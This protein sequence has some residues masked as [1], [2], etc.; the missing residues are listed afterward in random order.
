MRQE[1]V[2]LV[3]AVA[4]P[5]VGLL[6]VL[7]LGPGGL[8]R[9]I[10][11]QL[12][13][14]ATSIDELK[15]Q[16]NQLKEA[17]ARISSATEHVT[18]LRTQLVAMEAQLSTVRTYT[19]DLVAQSFVADQGITLT[20]DGDGSSSHVPSSEDS[21]RT[22]QELYSLINRKWAELC[23][24]L[25]ARLGEDNFDGRSVGDAAWRLTDKRRKQPLAQQQAER[26]ESLF[27]KMK[28]FRRLQPSLDDWLS[29]EVYEAFVAG[30]DE[31]ISAIKAL[32]RRTGQ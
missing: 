13:S 4:W 10:I 8:L 12:S 23:E 6:A 15:A 32:P 1:W 28:R 7:I 14:V 11:K 16:V 3:A 25:R 22:P 26:I 31:S 5:L 18:T 27:A 24:E 21:S 2:D 20:E 9:D 30:V 17:E 29:A 19:S